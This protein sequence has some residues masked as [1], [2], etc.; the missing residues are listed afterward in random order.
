MRFESDASHHRVRMFICRIL[1]ASQVRENGTLPQAL[2]VAARLLR[3]VGI[4]EGT[5]FRSAD[6]S[7]R[8]PDGTRRRGWLAGGTDRGEAVARLRMR[9]TKGVVESL[10]RLGL[11]ATCSVT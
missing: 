8:K 7:D 6:T 3:T 5:V 11:V 1:H 9:Q 2:Q 10:H 4:R